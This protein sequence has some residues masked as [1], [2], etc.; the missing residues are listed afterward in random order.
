MT[1]QEEK[2]MAWRLADGS[3]VFDFERALELVQHRPAEA[4]KLLRNRQKGRE[5][6]EELFRAYERLRLAAR[7]FR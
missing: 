7:E 5:R 4:E 2:D 1:E 3:E 6:R